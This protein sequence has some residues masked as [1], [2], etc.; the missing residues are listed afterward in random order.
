M[1]GNDNPYKIL[2][3]DEQASVSEIKKA[4]RKLALKHHP[5]RQ[6]TEIDRKTATDKFAKI[7]GAYEMLS[8]EEERR[9]YDSLKGSPFGNNAT[10]FTRGEVPS[11]YTYTGE[12]TGRPNARTKTYTYFSSPAGSSKRSHKVPKP[13]SSD[14]ESTYESSFQFQDPEVLFRQMFGGRM[15]VGDSSEKQTSTSKGK[16]TRKSQPMSMS[17]NTRTIRHPD[18]RVET[19]TETVVVHADGSTERHSS[20]TVG[21]FRN[22]MVNQRIGGPRVVSQVTTSC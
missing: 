4:Y 22:P 16:T 11:N 7:S 15:P 17:S 6:T 5:D 2:G 14:P 10:E 18:G 20:K 13:K 21:P 3:I 19:I 1:E 9:K 12:S 8:D